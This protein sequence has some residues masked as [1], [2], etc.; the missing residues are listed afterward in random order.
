M[1]FYILKLVNYIGNHGINSLSEA[2]ICNKTLEKLHLKSNDFELTN[3][4]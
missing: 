4:E 2:L 3:S 1:Y